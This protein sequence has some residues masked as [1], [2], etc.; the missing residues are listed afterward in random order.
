MSKIVMLGTG[1]GGTIN[2]YNTCFVIKNDKGNFL[3]DTGGSIEIINRLNKIGINIKELTDIFISH[4]HADHILGIFWLF[5]KLGRAAINGQIKNKINIYCNDSVYTAIREV[6]K[7]IL[8]EKLMNAVYTVINFKILNDFYHYT[9]NGI[10]YEFFDIH[11]KGDKQYGFKCEIDGKKLVFLGDEDMNP[12]LSDRVRNAD[13]V[14]HEA[15]C[16]D[17]EENI[18]HAYEKNHSTVKSACEVMNKLNVKNLILYH[19]ED[20]HG[21]EKKKLYTQEGIEYFNGELIVPDELEEIKI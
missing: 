6:S 16:L 1:N 7:Y 9:I 20:S 4:Q 18:F 15:F 13:Y 2:L 19:T 10:D 17:S 21:A 5:K 12:D 14:M 8:P 3:V 11:A